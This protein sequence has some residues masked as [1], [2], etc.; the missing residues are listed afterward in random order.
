[1]NFFRLLMIGLAAT[2]ASA[3]CSS[4]GPPA[5]TPGNPN[6][7]PAPTTNV[8]AVLVNAG[9][10]GVNAVNTLYTSV[11]LCVPGSTT[12]CQTI[13]NIEI[14]TQSSGLRILAPVLTI[15]LPLILDSNNNANTFAECAQFADSVSWGPL[16]R[17][18]LTIAGESAPSLTVQLIG[19]A[20]FA[21]IPPACAGAGNDEDTVA[22]FGANGILG[23]GTPA[24]D[25]GASCAGS[26]EFGFY[27]TCTSA[28]NCVGTLIDIADQMQNPATLFATDNNGLI[29][30]LPN[31][32]AAGAESVTGAIVFGIDTASNNA[33]G[34]ATV[35][36]VETGTSYLSAQ[37]DAQ[38]YAAR[39]LDTGSN[40]LFFNDSS[41]TQCTGSDQSFYCPANTEN[42]S[43]TLIAYTASGTG[44]TQATVNF[45]IAN[46]DTL[47]SDD[48]TG[49][50]FVNLGGIFDGTGTADTFD[51]GLPFFYGRSVYEVFEG[52][53]SSVGTGPY[54]AF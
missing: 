35:L 44:G 27:Y 39:F 40:G 9:P 30:E 32:S 21:T 5:A 6:P 7:I 46:A 3:A 52:K 15:T 31:V 25:C 22:T 47:L 14:D 53:S 50:A 19:D 16:A 41:L 24:Q 34:K 20:N 23:V 11:T 4:K 38:N 17:A 36:A 13:D 37:F 28:G 43:A 48:Q 33:S 18:D 26:T 29:I 51:F 45:S 49:T 42:L 54:F 8:A 10:A 2:M 12:S 1:M